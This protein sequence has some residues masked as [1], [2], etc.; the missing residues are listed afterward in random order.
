M[1]KNAKTEYERAVVIGVMDI[2]VSIL[3]AALYRRILFETGPV[4]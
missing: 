3:V 1:A 4:V 2:R